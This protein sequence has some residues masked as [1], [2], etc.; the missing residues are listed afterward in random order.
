[1]VAKITM[2]EAALSN[3][4]FMDAYTN[5]GLPNKNPMKHGKK[6]GSHANSGPARQYSKFLRHKGLVWQSIS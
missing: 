3:K 2:K 1:M 6:T 4:E 5:L